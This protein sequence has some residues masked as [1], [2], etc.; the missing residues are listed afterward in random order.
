M[1]QNIELFEG[2]KEQNMKDMLS[3]LCAYT[4]SYKK[5]EFVVLAGDKFDCLGIVTSG[6]VNVVK[7]SFYGDRRIMTSVEKNAIFAESMVSA[8]INISPVS[9]VA[10][11]DCT[12]LFVP[13][14]KILFTCT[15]SC[16]YHN[17]LIHNLVAI[18]AKKNIAL[19]QKIDYL[20]AKTTREKIAKYF[21]DCMNQDKTLTITIPYNRNDLAQ[22]LGVDRS[23]LSRE[24]SSLK[25]EGILA[26]DKNTFNILKPKI[27]EELY[28]V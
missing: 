5:N 13:F 2:I 25:K 22:Y 9:V 21:G 11:D 12:I 24:L 16:S 1:H 23:V 18:L 27:L 4:K 15:N 19:N 7:E 8:G 14:D 20:S 3:C 26:F 17:R 28:S 6:S 10:K